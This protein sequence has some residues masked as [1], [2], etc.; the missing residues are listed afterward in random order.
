SLGRLRDSTK[1]VRPGR[2]D[3]LTGEWGRRVQLSTLDLDRPVGSLSGGNQQKVVLAKWMMMDPKV[4]LLDEPTQGVDI[5]AKREILNLI[6]RAVNDG[7]AVIVCGTDALELAELCT[8]VLIIRNGAV[9]ETLEG[10]EV[11][12]DAITSAVYP[13]TQCPSD[14]ASITRGPHQGAAQLERS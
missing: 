6:R 14:S 10:T 3:D 1:L 7:A 2:E 11:N 13:L 9:A 12:A 5:G 4:Y 8:R